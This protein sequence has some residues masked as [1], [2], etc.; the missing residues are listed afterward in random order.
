MRVNVVAKQWKNAIKTGNRIFMVRKNI[1]HILLIT[2][3][4]Q[5]TTFSA[6]FKKTSR[7]T[8][9]VLNKKSHGFYSWTFT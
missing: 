2:P 6:K 3:N 7:I 5:K 9:N 1:I 8:K 4:A